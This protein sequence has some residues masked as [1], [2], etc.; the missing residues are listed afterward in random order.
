[1]NY[2]SKKQRKF[3]L[4]IANDSGYKHLFKSLF[5]FRR[6]FDFF[7]FQI[8]V[9]IILFLIAIFCHENFGFED[10]QF[11]SIIIYN[12]LMILVQLFYLNIF[13][14]KINLWKIFFQEPKK[15]H[16]H[17]FVFEIFYIMKII[18]DYQIF[19]L[20]KNKDLEND[21]NF[22]N[23]NKSLYLINDFE[24]I[25]IFCTFLN[26]I[27]FQYSKKSLRIRISSRIYLVCIVVIFMILSLVYFIYISNKSDNYQINKYFRFLFME[28]RLIIYLCFIYFNFLINRNIEKLFLHSYQKLKNHKQ[29][30]H[31]FQTII[32][33]GHNQGLFSYE[34]L[35]KVERKNLEH[36]ITRNKKLD[37]Y[38]ITFNSPN[39][40]CNHF[41]TNDSNRDNKKDINI[42]FRNSNHKNNSL[43]NNINNKN[44]IQYD[45]TI[46]KGDEFKNYNLIFQS[47][48]FLDKLKFQLL[49]PL[50]RV[51]QKCNNENFQSSYLSNINQNNDYHS[52]LS[53]IN[54]NTHHLTSDR[55]ATISIV[56]NS[57][58]SIDKK[59]FQESIVFNFN[60]NLLNKQEK[61]NSSNDKLENTENI[62]MNYK[63][64][65]NQD[66]FDDNSH[67]GKKFPNKS[68]SNKKFKNT[69]IKKTT[70]IAVIKSSKTL[71]LNI[72]DIHK[73][74]KNKDNKSYD[75]K[76]SSSNPV[77]NDLFELKNKIIQS[78]KQLP[79]ID[80]IIE[81]TDCQK[82]D[83]I[84]LKKSIKNEH[85]SREIAGSKV[86]NNSK[87]PSKFSVTFNIDDDKD[88]AIFLPRNKS[89]S[90]K[91]LI[92]SPKNTNIKNI[93]NAN[94]TIICT[95]NGSKIMNVEKKIYSKLSNNRTFKKIRKM[96]A[97]CSKT[98]KNRSNKILA[99]LKNNIF[100]SNI[101]DR[102]LKTQ[103]QQI[104]KI[105]TRNIK[106]INYES[107]F[108]RFKKNFN[109]DE[110]I[111]SL[112][113]REK[114]R[115]DKF[116]E[117]EFQALGKYPNEVN[118]SSKTF[119]YYLN[120][121]D[122]DEKCIKNKILLKPINIGI[123]QLKQN[124]KNQEK[125]SGDLN[126]NIMDKYSLIS[127][128][129]KN[130]VNQGKNQYN[131][132][133]IKSEDEIRNKNNNNEK[134][135]NETYNK[136]DQLTDTLISNK[137]SIL[138]NL[139]KNL[140]KVKNKFISKHI[141]KNNKKLFFSKKRNDKHRFHQNLIES[142]I[143]KFN[144]KNKSRSNSSS[145]FVTYS[146]NQYSTNRKKSTIRKIISYDKRWNSNNV[147]LSMNIN[148]KDNSPTQN[149]STEKIGIKNNI[150]NSKESKQIIRNINKNYSKF[151]MKQSLSLNDINNLLTSKYNIHS[152]SSNI[153]NNLKNDI[154]NNINGILI[155]E[156]S[157]N[158]NTIILKQF[159]DSGRDI[160]FIDKKL[161]RKNKCLKLSKDKY[162]SDFNSYKSFGNKEIDRFKSEKNKQSHNKQINMPRLIENVNLKNYKNENINDVLIEGKNYM[163]NPF[164]RKVFT[165]NNFNNNNII[166]CKCCCYHTR[167]KNKRGLKKFLSKKTLPIRQNILA[168]NTHQNQNMDNNKYEDKYNKNDQV[169]RNNDFTEHNQTKTH[170]NNHK[171]N[172]T[173][174]IINNSRSILNRE[175]SLN[176]SPY[177]KNNIKM[178]KTISFDEKN[179]FYRSNN[180]KKYNS[181]V[182]DKDSNYLEK[183]NIYKK[184]NLDPQENM[185]CN[186]QYN[187][188]IIKS[189]NQ[190]K[191]SKNKFLEE[192]TNLE[193]YELYITFNEN[194]FYNHPFSNENDMN[195][196]SNINI[197]M[198][199][200]EFYDKLPKFSDDERINYHL[201][202][203]FNK[204]KY[205]KLNTF[206]ELILNIIDPYE[207]FN[208]LTYI[209]PFEIIL[210][211]SK[212]ID[213]DFYINT[214]EFND[215]LLNDNRQKLKITNQNSNYKENSQNIIEEEHDSAD[216]ISRLSKKI[217]EK[218]LNQTYIK[219][220]N[221]LKNDSSNF[222]KENSLETFKRKKNVFIS[223]FK[224]LDESI[225]YKNI[226][227]NQ[228]LKD[229]QK[230]GLSDVLLE[231]NYSRIKTSMNTSI[232]L[233]N[234]MLCH[235]VEINKS[236]IDENIIRDRKNHDEIESRSYDNFNNKFSLINSI[237][238]YSKPKVFKK[239]SNKMNN[240]QLQEFLQGN[241]NFNSTNPVQVYLTK[242][243]LL[244]KT[245]NPNKRNNE[246][247]KKVK[248]NTSISKACG[249]LNCFKNLFKKK[250]VKLTKK[251]IILIIKDLNPL[252][253]SFDYNDCHNKNN[254][255]YTNNH[256]LSSNHYLSN[257]ENNQLDAY[258]NIRNFLSSEVNSFIPNTERKI[259]INN[260]NSTMNNFL[261]KFENNQK[262][263]AITLE[264]S[265]LELPS[266]SVLTINPNNVFPNSFLG[267]RNKT[268]SLKY[269]PKE[270][271]MISNIMYENLNSLNKKCLLRENIQKTKINYDI[272]TH[273]NI[274]KIKSEILNEKASKNYNNDILGKNK[275]EAKQN[276]KS[277]DKTD[278]NIDRKKQRRVSVTISSP[279]FDVNNIKGGQPKPH[280]KYR[281]RFD[282][283][284]RSNTNTNFNYFNPSNEKIANYFNNML[285]NKLFSISKIVPKSSFNSNNRI[286]SKN[287]NNI[288][289]ELRFLNTYKSCSNNTNPNNFPNNNLV[290]LNNS[291]NKEYNK[292]YS[293]N[294]NNVS[295]NNLKNYKTSSNSNLL[296]LDFFNKISAL[297]HDFKHI[298]YDNMIYFDYL[299]QKYIQPIILVNE[300]N[301]HPKSG[302]SNNVLKL[303]NSNYFGSFNNNYNN[304]SNIN[305][306]LLLNNNDHNLNNN[307][308]TILKMDINKLKDDLEYLSVIKD[309]TVSLILNITS[310]MSDNEFLAGTLNEPIDLVK[311]INLMVKI[312]NR[313]LEYENTIL[314]N[315]DLN[316]NKN[317]NFLS[318]NKNI[319][320]NNASWNINNNMNFTRNKKNININSRFIH[321]E[322]LINTKIYSNQNLVISLLYN[323][324]SNSYKYTDIGEIIIEANLQ[325]LDNVK[326]IQIKVSDTGKGIPD[327][328]LKNWGKPFNL[329]DKTQGTGLGQFLINSICKNLGFILLKP[330]KNQ[331]SKT[332]TVIK[333][334]IPIDLNIN[335][336][337]ISPI[338]MN[339]NCNFMN[340][341]NLL[342]WNDTNDNLNNSNKVNTSC[343]LPDINS[344]CL[345][346]SNR[347]NSNNNSNNL[348]LGNETFNNNISINNNFKINPNKSNISQNKTIAL[349]NFNINIDDKYRKL[350]LFNNSNLNSIRNNPTKAYIPNNRRNLFIKNLNHINSS[351]INKNTNTI[352]HM[353]NIANDC[354]NTSFNNKIKNYKN[355]IERNL[356]SNIS[357]KGTKNNEVAKINTN[358]SNNNT[359]YNSSLFNN[360]LYG[361][362]KSKSISNTKNNSTIILPGNNFRKVYILCLDDDQLFLGMLANNLKNIAIDHPNLIFNM[363]F[364]NNIKDFFNEFI[365]LISE[366][367]VID[368]FI[369]DQNISMNMKGIDCCKIVN[370]FYKL[371]FKELYPDLKFKFFFVTEDNN[372]TN[373][374][375]RQRKQNLIRKDHVFGKMQFKGLCN[376]LDE[377]LK[378][379]Y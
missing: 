14:R 37:N 147:P 294:N 230:A 259:R 38:H 176:K 348:N 63:N 50:N 211:D 137:K 263:T 46:K 173:N 20:F 62:F 270:Q 158:T 350:S 24:K 215:D 153:A 366:N 330:E 171:N 232:T 129:Y 252:S 83:K 131:I 104:S 210:I 149:L 97:N 338:N 27:Y 167:Y 22:S 99:K 354:N 32:E 262:Y 156:S 278:K 96:T 300:L 168:S 106:D 223:V 42:E 356:A 344:N 313:R 164:H 13:K 21:S 274:K 7:Y 216:H 159:H 333:I 286:I 67:R 378:S 100:K 134:D 298:V 195:T 249:W 335:I 85:S 31:F 379:K 296:H 332:G 58:S 177:G 86:Q 197:K 135:N 309:F 202:T 282:Y 89:H 152:N 81:K 141:N 370:K 369:M 322:S 151:Q 183:Y 265:N 140:N 66:L 76:R 271:T 142:D 72:N 70:K 150:N 228:N 39:K 23:N 3:N 94:D 160:R 257:Y 268:Q 324:I 18:S 281:N 327:E 166:L 82:N 6:I 222:N 219:Y 235:S 188:D 43:D 289:S 208:F 120:S 34:K 277:E 109:K 365:E 1:M 326:F 163:F 371:Y 114:N 347:V 162:G 317:Q 61:D 241:D 364:K 373:F 2:F 41:P 157:K 214:E 203:L 225:L 57:S 279:S 245:K 180:E 349:Q 196:S 331:F 53:N 220:K 124:E 10:Y 48:N 315:L 377:Y 312:F 250:Y 284:N 16:I 118:L 229:P 323:L 49:F 267:R 372:I 192:N 103:S 75:F 127:N 362:L 221:Y 145:N 207:E 121:N 17:S 297:L 310:F 69:N 316:L 130:G 272:R 239:D 74:K 116:N 246:I 199:D 122:L 194:H 108:S 178:Q 328:I 306:G 65:S 36:N 276:S 242:D 98:N 80:E 337:N 172:S 237:I 60:K 51:Y 182:D 226:E 238:D 133:V 190:P 144:S 8:I 181:N 186:D 243:N 367:I 138:P 26:A 292:I 117:N 170:I 91:K 368:Y 293:L 88:N 175:K 174:N 44:N 78:L 136:L 295:A 288:L 132:E 185:K 353:N 251:K 304:N 184:I 125:P 273:D 376:K 115:K 12:L 107:S 302:M 40:L 59:T 198:N 123:A 29:F 90:I 346:N 359:N 52:N 244:S 285:D 73:K 187:K 105:S 358:N 301:T 200:F 47:E 339:N 112:Y 319:H 217:T 325:V 256:L 45:S 363:T 54:K 305:S 93:L 30:L 169:L 361:K 155:D 240:E 224:F 345:C 4:L 154:K 258:S 33:Q 269:Y 146:S 233:N 201:L 9:N 321:L 189:N 334:L 343:N 351:Y 340:N 318:S 280:S 342:Y 179:I 320:C 64:K 314:E 283:M 95:S 128:S 191:D 212:K 148:P 264:N 55:V 329:Y 92:F 119:S 206:I 25:L 213:I 11:F 253:I 303:N 35:L 101:R 193:N 110:H 139:S 375:I 161:H 290:N 341:N 143:C 111:Y 307:I 68:N 360:L 374:S 299:I 126:K 355:N 113:R 102:S 77:L 248:N 357:R 56:N 266:S 311:I 275:K 236:N 247:N 255:N 79:N 291:L 5:P 260:M 234:N 218:Q 261:T 352:I 287:S 209:G 84:N 231:K 227:C 71:N 19:H 15:N 165:N 205:Y 28:I 204:K 308:S 336:L 87:Y 254:F